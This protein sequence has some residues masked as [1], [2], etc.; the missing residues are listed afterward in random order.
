MGVDRAQ[1]QSKAS[2]AA[3]NDHGRD[4]EHDPGMLHAAQVERE[5]SSKAA[6]KPTADSLSSVQV[7]DLLGNG[8]ACLVWSS[9]LPGAPSAPLCYVDLM[10]GRI[11]VQ[12]KEGEGT[13]F[14]V[15][16]PA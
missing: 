2:S 7:A 6:T 10:G 12:S 9:P 11:D 3:N 5:R 8:T 14:R 13:T 1:K 15:E 4:K 16:L